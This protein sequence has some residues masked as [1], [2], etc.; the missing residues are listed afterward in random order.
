MSVKLDIDSLRALKSIADFGGVTRAAQHLS[1]SQSAVSHKIKR[2]EEHI[3]CKVLSRR[4]G[5]HLLTEEGERLLGYANRILTLHD[6]AAATL[7]KR[8]LS[9]RIR[10][11]MTEDMTSSGL[12]KV[13][14]RF[15]HVFPDVSVRVHVS[16][17]KVLQREVEN[18]G[19]DLSVMQVFARDVRPDD[20]VLFTHG[21]CWA[22]SKDYVI[23][24]EGPIPFL[25]YDDECFYKEWLMDNV[26][27]LGRDFQTVLQCSSNGGI[28][29]AI[30]AGLGISIINERQVSAKMDVV[31]DKVFRTP[32]EIAYVVRVG[33]SVSSNA[34]RVLASE[35]A[36]E[37]GDGHMLQIN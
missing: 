32:P 18:G 6:E 2:L 7:G 26:A 8:R 25:S 35:I 29:A 12:A 21:V 30:E 4:G 1:L 37:A 13:L 15:S 22:K 24:N 14:A 36:D 20:L 27:T 17:S 16:Q 23:P 28:I 10:M 11:G 19:V 34:V 31:E 9:G 3:D 33:A 5:D